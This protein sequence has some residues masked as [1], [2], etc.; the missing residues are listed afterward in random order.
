M[1]FLVSKRVKYL[2]NSH[3]H[4]N[5]EEKEMKHYL[6]NLSIQLQSPVEWHE[7]PVNLQQSP[8][9]SQQS[10]IKPLLPLEHGE[11]QR[12]KELKVLL[13]IDKS[14]QASVTEACFFIHIGILG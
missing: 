9:N 13:N 2:I 5:H 10:L 11:I 12:L 3:Y 8:V 4:G 6:Q 14:S 1:D 7:S